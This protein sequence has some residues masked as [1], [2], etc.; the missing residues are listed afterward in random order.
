MGF[1]L[2][3]DNYLVLHKLVFASILYATLIAIMVLFT[4]TA[5]HAWRGTRYPFVLWMAAATITNVL[6]YA[7][8]SYC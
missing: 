2:R 1:A 6:I 3:L 7:G 8:Y 5:I 4:I